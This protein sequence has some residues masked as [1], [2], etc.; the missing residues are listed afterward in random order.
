LFISLQGASPTAGS[1]RIVAIVDDNGS[2]RW[3]R[4]LDD[5]YGWASALDVERGVIDVEVAPSGQTTTEWWA[6]DLLTGESRVETE[7]S[8]DELTAALMERFG[9]PDVEYNLADPPGTARLQRVDSSGKVLWRRDDVFEPFGEGFRTSVN[10]SNGTDQVTLVF[11]CVG[12]PIDPSA[13]NMDER[14]P[15]ALL[16]IGTKNGQT[17]WQLDG[18]YM[19]PL[20][21]DGYA[22]ITPIPTEHASS[23]LLDVFTGK[24]VAGGISPEPGAFLS[25]CCGGYDYNRVQADGAVAWTVDFD[26]LNVWYPADLPGPGGGAL[27]DLLGPSS[28]AQV[29]ATFTGMTDQPAECSPVLCW[30]YHAVGS[31]FPPGEP[32]TASCWV[33]T[34]AGWT[35]QG[36]DITVIASADGSVLVDADCH[37]GQRARHVKIT[38]DDIDSNVLTS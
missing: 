37:V 22:I 28:T 8:A 6:F 32:V 38:I 23:Q 10:Q 9:E 16:G 34:S 30:Q 25:E 4:C 31:G 15:F 2:V 29:V 13:T 12:Q 5:V 14:C 21:A 3:R 20:V 11:G 18:S 17:R 36:D 1:R 27:V 19:V 26:V 33:E 24:V 35:Q 7:R